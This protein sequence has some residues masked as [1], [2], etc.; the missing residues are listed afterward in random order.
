MFKF[1]FALV[2]FATISSMGFIGKIGKINS[3]ATIEPA[4]VM[5][6]T[7]GSIKFPGRMPAPDTVYELRRAIQMEDIEKLN[8]ILFENHLFMAPSN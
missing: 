8:E 7:N 1:I 4:P 5:L 6:G 2:A 3:P